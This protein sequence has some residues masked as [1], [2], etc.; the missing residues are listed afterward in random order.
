MTTPQ[1]LQQMLDA[2]STVPAAY[3]DD[4]R[5]VLVAPQAVL[6]RADRTGETTPIG[7]YNP[8]VGGSFDIPD[9]VP[10]NVLDVASLSLVMKNAELEVFARSIG[11]NG[12]VAPVVNY[13]NRLQSSAIN[14]K[15]NGTAYPISGLLLGREVKVGDKVVYGATVG[16]DYVQHSSFVQDVRAIT[17]AAVV[18]SAAAGS[19][20][21]G[22][23]GASASSSQVAGALNWITGTASA[24]SYND[25]N[26]GATRIYTVVV[27]S[28]GDDS[29]ARLQVISSDGRDDVASIA[30]AAFSS[31][32]NIGS[33]GLTFTWVI[34][35]VRPVDSGA[36]TSLFVVGQKWQITAVNAFNA[37]TA[38][39]SGSYTADQDDTIIVTVTRGGLYTDPTPPQITV[40]TS[41]SLDSSGPTNITNAG[42][43]YAVGTKG[44]LVQFNQ[45]GL[46]LGDIFHIPVTAVAETHMRILVLKDDLPTALL[47][48]AD[49]DLSI[50]VVDSALTVRK[51][52][53]DD[54][55]N[56]NWELADPQIVVHPGVTGTSTDGTLVDVN[57]ALR[58]VPVVTGEMHVAYREWDASAVD[59]LQFIT[60]P[61]DA[62][63]KLGSI[64]SDNPAGYMIAQ[65]L[66]CSDGI[67]VGLMGV[68]DPASLSSWEDSITALKS[69]SKCYH[70]CLGS[71]SPAVISLLRDHLIDQNSSTKE[72]FRCGITALEL[73]TA[74]P[75]V[76]EDTTVGGGTC[77]ATIDD[78]PSTANTQY[79]YVSS[80]NGQFVTNGVKAGDKL[81]TAYTVDAYGIASYSEFTVSS[82]INEN[83]LVI[84]PSSSIPYLVAQ[85]I[86]IHRTAKSADL[87]NYITETVA[88]LRSKYLVVCV[89]GVG[90]DLN[91]VAQPGYALACNL[92]AA[93][94]AVAPHQ[95]L[96]Y[97]I[98][99]GYSRVYGN[100]YYFQ[101]NQMKT[102]EEAGVA[103][104][105]DDRNG[106]V[107]IRRLVT[108]D[109]DNPENSYVRNE[110]AIV[111]ILRS[112]LA[113]YRGQANRTNA[114]IGKMILDLNTAI[115][116]IQAESKIILLGS[117][118]EGTPT[119]NVRNHAQLPDYVV[120]ELQAERPYP[121]N[122]FNVSF[123]APVGQ[124]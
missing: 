41:K 66:T 69:A 49:G 31:P 28:G 104:F 64:E 45:T 16:P 65:M 121:L 61:A 108:T 46:C 43:N 107:F 63:E 91:D 62:I 124:A 4:L 89:P 92:A 58:Y 106:N 6:H 80:A 54:E 85:K 118:L 39:A 60:D 36:P 55:P 81:R 100:G 115:S 83:T 1:T 30:P 111:F 25:L 47:G 44:V 79:N 90:Y 82:V 26:G 113:P 88:Q 56:Y 114:V 71:G 74:L 37:P 22:T 110:H 17:S 35:N 84:T 68:A 40:T 119:V 5:A 78:N 73:P 109:L 34:D 70:I 103:V 116:Q 52:R 9:R 59:Q 102:L 53:R 29:S 122:D 15:N 117:M 8:A 3:N 57:G 97:C 101:P 32:T 21:Q 77:L 13:K 120:V 33:K 14:F 2:A 50:R 11:V 75:I 112:K 86:E 76:T 67:P 105:D 72:N 20:N 51:E 12:T 10:A 18:G 93:L 123:L 94:S 98:I 99:P 7:T 19:G 27:I 87:V 95:P 38:T 48:V 24:A 42:T 23:Q 96:N